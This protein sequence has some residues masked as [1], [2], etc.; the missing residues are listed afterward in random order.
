[1]KIDWKH[2]SKTPGYISLKKAVVEAHTCGRSFTKKAGHY[3]T[4][5][6]IISRAKHYAYHLN[7][8]LE[9]VLNEWEAKRNYSYE[10]YYQQ[11]KFPKLNPSP[12]VRPLSPK[13]YYKTNSWYRDPVKRKAANFASIVR[14]QK[15]KSKR[16]GRTAR[17]TT[18]MKVRYK[19][20]AQYRKE[21]AMQKKRL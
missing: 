13:N 9:E 2:V 5:N 18:E 19:R 20:A 6:W 4:F 1:M 12:L 10:N 7:K 16:Q 11:S 21:F 3:K 14:K 17:W 8:T 15:H